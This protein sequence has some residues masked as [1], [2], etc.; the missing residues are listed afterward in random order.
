[1]A[2]TNLL[3]PIPVHALLRQECT[4]LY[5]NGFGISPRFAQRFET[6]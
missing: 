4:L 2:V 5:R 1:M 3:F 6:V